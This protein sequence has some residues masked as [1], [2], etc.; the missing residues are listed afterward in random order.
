MTTEKKVPTKEEIL[1]R[2][3][4]LGV[5]F[6]R[7]QFTDILGVVKNVALPVE[8][9]GK[10]LD[11]EIMFDGSSIEGFTRIEESDMNLR[12]DPS[13][14]AVFPW[15]PRDGAV[16]RLICDVYTADGKPFAGDPR[17]VLKRAMD[18]AAS[19]GFTVMAGPECEFF[20]F[21]T[22]AEGNPTTVTHDEAGYFDLA[23]VDKGE[24]A[25][26]EIVLA[27]SEMGFDIEAS[28]HEVAR[29]Q[30]EIDFKYGDCLTTADRVVTLKLAT[31]AVAAKHGLCATFMPKPLFDVNGSGMHVHLS[32][33]AKGKNVFYDPSG[34]YQL[35]ETARQFIAGILSHAPGITAVANPL[36]N[37]Y[38]RL[39]PGYE[40]PVYIS[41]SAVNR[42]ALIRV[43][44]AR[45]SGTRVEFRSPDPSCNPYLAFAAIISAGLDGIKKKMTP[46]A[47]VHE[48]IYHMTEEQRAKAG[49]KSLP[50][51]LKEA[52]ELLKADKVIA[53]ALGEHVLAHFVAAKNAEWDAFRIRVHGWEIDRYLGIY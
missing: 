26:R 50:G 9:L 51:S 25:R 27:L 47:S 44:A 39:V 23:P 6:V 8:Q 31:R 37:S 17:H 38:K 35:S 32:L 43:P 29:G 4:E 48:N 28:H 10:A 33:F 30:H 20:F 46:P 14:F 5:S 45:E 7:L 1:A 12:P 49:I 21:Q 53:D 19:M 3:R 16:A 15:R 22:D 18:E 40:A 36:V 34:E 41:W 13:T 2:A 52:V 11:N 42:S 24:D